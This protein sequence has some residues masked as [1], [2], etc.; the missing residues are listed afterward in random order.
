MLFMT[1]PN[2]QMPESVEL[3]ESSYSSTFGRFIVQP[4]E[5][6][7]GTTI[8][9]ALRRVL[10]SSLPGAAITTIRIDGVHHEFSTI[11][12]VVEDVAEIILNLKEV[13]FKLINKKPDKVVIELKGPHEF[14]AGDIQNGTTDFEILNPDHHIATLNKGA[15]LKIELRIGRGHG[16]VPAEEN[17]LPDM[18]IGSIPIDAIYTPIKNVSYRVE[19]MRVQQRID[20]ERLI[21]EITTDGSITPDDALTYAGKI[22]RDHINLFINFDIK[23]EIEEE[24]PTVD[25]EVLRIRKLLKMSVDELELSVRSYNCLMAANIKTI[26]DLVR[27][28]E[29]EMLKFRNFGRKSLQELTQILEEKGLHFGMEVEKYLGNGHD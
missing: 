17:K 4:L 3:E 29:Q 7:F 23:P 20:Y 22:L 26:G 15:D 27:R 11:P 10:L 12:G 1:W 25:E 13:R 16:Y 21:I 6:G 18:P 28:D 2:L 9:N 8:G 14:T 24:P 5:R 19:N